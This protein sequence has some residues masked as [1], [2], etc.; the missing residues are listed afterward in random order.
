M[1][2]LPAAPPRRR[3]RRILA[4]LAAVA[5]LFAGLLLWALFWPAPRAAL[6]C[7]PGDPPGCRAASGRVLYV[8]RKDSKLRYRAL[9]LVLV[10]RD[11]VA[12]PGITVVKIP[13]VYRQRKT[14]RI[15]TWV[16]VVGVPH[17]GSN[18]ETD[19]GVTRLLIP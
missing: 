19:L 7:G 12:L 5:A 14:P 15:G 8:P 3:L 16:S 11:S 18:G 9:H 10:S 4:A 13:A 6:R 17:R 1:T 2:A